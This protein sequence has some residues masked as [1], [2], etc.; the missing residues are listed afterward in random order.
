MP[1]VAS[2]QTA[3]S[4]S[5]RWRD[6]TETAFSPNSALAAASEYPI[7]ATSGLVNVVVGTS[8]PSFPGSVKGRRMFL[9]ATAPW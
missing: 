9:A 8:F 2:S 4:T 5:L 6:E 1:L 7:V 3:R